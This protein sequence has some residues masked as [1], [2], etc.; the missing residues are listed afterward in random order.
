VIAWHKAFGVQ[1]PPLEIIL[2]GS[3]VYLALYIMLRVVLKRQSGSTGITDLL[4]IV[5]IADAAQNA[6]SAGY[7]SITD[8]LIL[9]ATIIGWSYLLDFLAFRFPWLARLIQPSPLPLVRN[10]DMIRRNMRRELITEEELRSQLRQQGID[11]MAKVKAAF[12]EPDGQVSVVTGE[13]HSGPR[14][15][16]R[17]Y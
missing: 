3:I 14:R 7:S 17:T 11:D 4:V 13:R 9:V 6:M 16:K 2:R 8:G 12:M 5:L 15:D 10:G 1:T